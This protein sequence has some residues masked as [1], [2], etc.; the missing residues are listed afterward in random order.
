MRFDWS[1]SVPLTD[2]VDIGAAS[3][4]QPS[5]S[6]GYGAQYGDGDSIRLSR[7]KVKQIVT[8]LSKYLEMTKGFT[9]KT[10]NQQIE[11][12]TNDFPMG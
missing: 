3:D 2:S 7:G 5:I 12:L 6:F 8:I 10:L 1:L 9:D 11:V 4:H